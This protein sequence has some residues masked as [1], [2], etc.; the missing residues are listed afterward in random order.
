MRIFAKGLWLTSH[1][2]IAYVFD[3]FSYTSLKLHSVCHHNPNEWLS[4]VGPFMKN[5]SYVWINIL[6]DPLQKLTF[7]LKP[8]EMVWHNLFA[9]SCGF[10]RQ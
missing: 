8:E 2:V 5:W 7:L 3:L 9:L 10:N 4:N 1:I 6:N